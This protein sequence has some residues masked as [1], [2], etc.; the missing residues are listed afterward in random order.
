MIEEGA[1]NKKELQDL[2]D[3]ILEIL[4]LDKQKLLEDGKA[5]DV[6]T[7][8]KKKSIQINEEQKIAAKTEEEI[9]KARKNYLPVS[10]EAS[11]LFF[12]IQDLGFI[13][14]MYQYSLTYFIDLFTFS[15]DK[16]MPSEELHVRLSSISEH[17]L[18]SL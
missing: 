12:A 4:S 8:S 11:C 13:D 16:S 14:P 6:L 3:A 1:K 2:E 10:Q 5:I 17:F 18:F 7:A 15:I 9:D